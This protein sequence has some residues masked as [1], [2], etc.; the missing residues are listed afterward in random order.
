MEAIF[1]K[2]ER[3]FCAWLEDETKKWLSVRSALVKDEAISVKTILK[4]LIE[5]QGCSSQVFPYP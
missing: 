4:T 2:M 3:E 5:V 1:K